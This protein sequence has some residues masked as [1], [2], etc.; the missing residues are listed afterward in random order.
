MGDSS[1]LLVVVARVKDVIFRV[2]V[3]LFPIHSAAWEV[4][5]LAMSEMVNAPAAEQTRLIKRWRESTLAQLSQVG[6]IVSLREFQNCKK[7]A[8]C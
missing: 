8:T 7:I 5:Y 1:Q 6:L 3:Q 4:A 2:W